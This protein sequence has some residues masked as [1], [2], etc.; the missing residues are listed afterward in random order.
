MPAIRYTTDS[1]G[2]LRC[3]PLRG[4]RK[5]LLVLVSIIVV[6]ATLVVA[7][8]LATASAPVRP[9]GA[10]VV[11]PPADSDEEVLLDT[12]AAVLETA[13]TLSSSSSQEGYG[14]CP[15]NLHSQCFPSAKQ[16]RETSPKQD[17]SHLNRTAGRRAKLHWPDKLLGMAIA[18]CDLQSMGDA[19]VAEVLV[20]EGARVE[21]MTPPGKEYV[22]E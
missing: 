2:P 17:G 19:K 13:E 20:V 10:T 8:S 4:P 7:M 16:P 11:V 21:A 18:P 3:T 22:E 15:Q 5:S 6:V 1:K 12:G 14:N 9:G